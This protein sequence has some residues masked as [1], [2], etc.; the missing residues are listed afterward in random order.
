MRLNRRTRSATDTLARRCAHDPTVRGVTLVLVAHAPVT[1]PL[2]TLLTYA[3][4]LVDNGHDP[5]SVHALLCQA[6][7]C[8]HNG[9][10]AAR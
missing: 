1:V 3:V 2:A 8:K 7:D 6:P 4:A 10:A 5:A 9:G